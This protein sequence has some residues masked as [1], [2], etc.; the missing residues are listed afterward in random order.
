MKTAQALLKKASIQ[1]IFDKKD[2]LKELAVEEYYKDLD[3]FK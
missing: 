3:F 1:D 2:L